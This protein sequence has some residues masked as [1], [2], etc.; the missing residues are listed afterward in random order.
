MNGLSAVYVTLGQ[1][2]THRHVAVSQHR[3]EVLVA[4]VLHQV[5]LTRLVRWRGGGTNGGD[6]T[7]RGESVLHG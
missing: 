3:Q 2:G 4:V 1:L 6:E 7:I 5:R